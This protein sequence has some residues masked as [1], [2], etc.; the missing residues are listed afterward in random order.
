[1]KNGKN[2]VELA[3][4][5]AR[6]AESKRD[7]VAP[8]AVLEMTAGGRLSGFNAEPLELT[9]LA[10]RQVGEYCGIPAQYYDR[11]RAEQ[12]ELLDRNVNAWIKSQAGE[13]RMIR[14]LDGKVRAVLSDRYRPLENYD[15]AEAVLPVLKDRNL[16]LVSCEITERR[17]YLKAVDKNVT[18]QIPTG[19]R[20]GDGTHTMFDMLSPAI[21]ISNSEVG[22]GALNVELGI[23]TK[24]CTNLAFFGAKVMRKYHV[25]GKHEMAEGMF[26][27]LTDKTKRVSDAATW[28][29]L[30]DVVTAAFDQVKFQSL[31]DDIGQTAQDRI[32]NDPVKVIEVTAKRF[33]L[34]E[35]EKSSVLRHLIE[36]GDLTRYGVF[37]AVTRTAEDLD[38]YDRATE[39]ERIGGQIIELPRSDW[40]TFAAAA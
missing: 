14:V 25:G 19:H 1:M 17:L 24:G 3:T 10:H 32:T 28:M 12:P 38:S 36:G 39:L 27:L 13:K 18:K 8:T 7:Y 22:S 26:E 9:N 29:Q 15:L 37:N 5:I 33:G 34:G 11:M 6:Q 30:R 31:A 4:E 20:M 40:Q 35:Q 21:T 16:M 23:F 2:L